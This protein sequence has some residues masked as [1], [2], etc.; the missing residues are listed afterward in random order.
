MLSSLPNLLT[1][2]RIVIIPA[3]VAL[4]Y[5]DTPL[6][7]WLALGAF[8]VAGVTDYLDGYI[9]RHRNEISALGRFLDPIADKLLI[10]S[11]IVILVGTRQIE[12]LTVIAA[13]IILCREILIS[14]LREYLAEFKVSVPVSYLAKWKTTIQM[15]AIGFL[16]VGTAGPENWPI[17]LIGEIGLWAAAL[18]TLTTGYDYLSHGMRHIMASK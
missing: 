1:L 12:G 14:G 10:A 8:A 3:L 13:I 15:L 9:A 16:I 6:G 7:R 17:K 18:L 5:V 11:V 2:S 4:I